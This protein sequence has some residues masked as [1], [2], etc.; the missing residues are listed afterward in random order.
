MSSIVTFYSYK[1]GVG[2]SMA[3]ANVAFELSLKGLKVLIVDW[4]LEAPG[5]EKYFS[6]YEIQT[7]GNG[8]LPLLLEVQRG[9]CPAYTDYLWKINIDKSNSIDF[10]HS[11]REKDSNYSTNL[12]NLDWDDF[13]SN[14]NGGTYLENLRTKWKSDY[15]IVLIDSRTGLSDT[16]GICTIFLPDV[17]VPMFTANAQSLYGVRDI[18]RLAQSA[19]RKLKNRRMPLTILPVPSRFGTRGE[20]KESQMWLDLFAEELKEF[21]TDWLPKWIHP[22][23][24]LE[25]IKIPQIDYFSFGEKLAVAEQGTNDPEGMGYIFS[26][27]ASLLSSDFT[28][29][30]S[31]M[32]ER[33]N[34]EKE[35][36]VSEIE[37]KKKVKTGPSF[38]YKYDIFISYARESLTNDWITRHFMPLFKEYLDFEIGDNTRFFIDTKEI[39]Y[40]ESFDGAINEA[41]KSSKLL[42]PIVSPKY[43]RNKST[44]SELIPFLERSE[45]TRSNLVFPVVIHDAALRSGNS[46]IHDIQYFNFGDNMHVGRTSVSSRQ[47]LELAEKTRHLARIIAEALSRVP[48]L[49]PDW[50]SS[51]DKYIRLKVSDI[52]N[53]HPGSSIPKFL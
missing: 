32:G 44:L 8:L 39:D 41:L 46:L 20:F 12:E 1:G 21:Y 17:I 36:Y 28:D 18:I 47:S 4:D 49:N 2:R 43:L 33:Y 52:L 13:F 11:G 23:K 15:D 6:N 19:R 29:I 40:G 10:L 48:I 9:T 37:V 51:N 27:I 14:N 5:L 26:K 7:T 31:L 30:E 24:V 16:S 50:P 38:D 53:D 3:L 34:S 45:L 42:V 25:R 22:K 35:K